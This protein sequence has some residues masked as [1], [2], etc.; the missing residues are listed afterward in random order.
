MHRK[1]DKSKICVY[2]DQLGISL[3]IK[4]ID[5]PHHMVDIFITVNN[6]WLW[7]VDFIARSS[8]LCIMCVYFLVG[9][10][11]NR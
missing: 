5:I 2:H 1:K 6:D 11:Q 4:V 8:Y 9:K 3:K 10:E 7:R